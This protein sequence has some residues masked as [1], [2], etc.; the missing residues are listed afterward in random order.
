MR[1]PLV[2]I[3]GTMLVWGLGL[4]G[5]GSSAPSATSVAAVTFQSAFV[6]ESIPALYTCDGKNIHPPLEWG[7][8]PAG[9]S[10]LAL[11]ILGLTPSPSTNRYTASI[12]WAV[13]GVNPGLHRLAAGQLPP[14]ARV[15]VNSEGKRR[16]SICPKTGNGERYQ[17]ELYAL[18]AS[19]GISPRFAGLPIFSALSNP[20]ASPLATAHGSF[21]AVYVRK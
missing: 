4:A 11:F 5:C 3:L 21:S 19:L 20:T 13:A 18:P 10:Q 12:E 1:R 16:Y 14:G 6:G 17:F 15:G 8:V 2:A 9:T 7:A